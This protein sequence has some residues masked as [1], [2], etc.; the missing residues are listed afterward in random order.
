[1]QGLFATWR[2]GGILVE[3]RELKSKNNKDW[4][5]YVVKVASLG[6]MHEL[7]CDLDQYNKL[8]EGQHLLFE[9]SFSERKTGGNTF[10]Q[11]D[12][13]KWGDLPAAVSKGVAA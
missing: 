12:L 1:M 4:R 7:Q 5:G 6:M 2:I 13:E 9:G 11:L 8:S 3:R 10:L